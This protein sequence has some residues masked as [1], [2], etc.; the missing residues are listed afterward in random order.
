[1]SSIYRGAQLTIVA[2]A[3]QD[4]THGLPG[5]EPYRR[6]PNNG[7][8]ETFGSICLSALP[9]DILGGFKYFDDIRNTVW[10][11]R[12]WTFQEAI[13]SR[14]RLLFT[15]SQLIFSCNT[16][17]RCE[18]GGILRND[19]FLLDGLQWCGPR[20]RVHSLQRGACEIIEKYCLR[21]MTHHTDALNAIASTLNFVQASDEYHIWAVP[22]GVCTS[23][24][25]KRQRAISTC[26]NSAALLDSSEVQTVQIYLDWQSLRPRPRRQGFP[27]WSPLGWSL[28][29]FRY[30]DTYEGCVFVDTPR[31]KESLSTNLQ[32]AKAN[33][34]GMAQHIS[35]PLK[36][37]FVRIYR[38]GISQEVGIKDR[39]VLPLGHGFAHKSS[40]IYWDKVV[41]IDCEMKL[42]IICSEYGNAVDFLI[43][44]AHKGYY[45]RVGWSHMYPETLRHLAE[46]T[47][48]LCLTDDKFKPMSLSEN[49]TLEPLDEERLRAAFGDIDKE[50][51]WYGED[52][53]QEELITLG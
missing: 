25:D 4:P 34:A 35:L 9:R 32:S 3:G 31:G 46:E 26:S 52:E 33:P 7:H 17:T 16:S 45:E 18:W 28:E 6:S 20:E 38:R 36:T 53:F 21:R 24:S 10:A 42:A 41:G 43:L 49:G 8:H 23:S 13:F 2:A 37:R 22:F 47:S 30:H 14:R 11:S 1:M 29:K 40:R 15:E 5:V 27:S 51:L 50:D 48:L 44:E 12:A 39:I 19:H